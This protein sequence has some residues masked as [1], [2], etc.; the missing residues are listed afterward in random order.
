MKEF[1]VIWLLPLI[2]L[3]C[4]WD[5]SKPN[6]EVIQD[7]M[8]SPAIKAQEYDEHSPHHSG[9][10][11]PPENTVPVGFHPYKYGTDV[12]KASREN[13]NPI[14]DEKSKEMVFAGVKQYETNCMVCHGMRGEGGA[15]LSVSQ[16]MA[17]KPPSLLSDKVKGMTD[18]Q[19]YHIITQGQGVM[20]PYAAQVPQA[21]RW[22]VVNYIRSLQKNK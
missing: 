20:G 15:E 5:K 11:L 13:R 6:V 14:A 4:S 18:A 2:F 19:I 3:G 1:R 17:L 9:M 22:Q 12:E 21:S 7:F 10:R 8:E 16:K